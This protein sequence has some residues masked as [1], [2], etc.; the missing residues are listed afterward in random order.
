[1]KNSKIKAAGWGA[2]AAFKTTNNSSYFKPFNP[3]TQPSITSDWLPSPVVYYKKIF[4]NIKQ[5]SEWVNVCCCFHSD[6]N[7]SLSINLKSGG[8][9]CH[10]CHA[11]G[12]DVI[13]FH[14]QHY[15][16][17]FKEALLQLKKI[18][19]GESK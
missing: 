1:M 2:K 12:G 5:C 8:F 6:N 4:P 9:F 7:P 16:L 14:Q 3:K 10:A 13:A 11:K 18:K 17:G 19:H 15:K